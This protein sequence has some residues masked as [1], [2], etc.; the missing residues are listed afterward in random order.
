MAMAVILSE[1]IRSSMLEF[2]A[3][4]S[5]FLDYDAAG[6]LILHLKLFPNLAISVINGAP[7]TLVFRNPRIEH[8][9]ITLYIHDIID[10][11]FYFSKTFANDKSNLHS[12]N[13]FPGLAPFASYFESNNKIR[14][15]TFDETMKNIFTVDTEVTIPSSPLQNWHSIVTNS[16]DIPQLDYDNPKENELT[17]YIIKVSP[18][19]RSTSFRYVNIGTQNEWGDKPYIESSNKNTEYFDVVNY[20]KTG[21]LGYLQEQNIKEIL[22]I[23]FKP[24]IQL[25]SSPRLKNGLEL[26]DFAFGKDGYL[27]LLESKSIAAYDGIEKSVSNKSK[28]C[29]QLLLAENIVSEKPNVVSHG[30]LFEHCIYAERIIKIC[31]VGDTYLINTK[32]LADSLKDYNRCDLPIIMSLGTFYKSLFTLRDPR[33]I[34][35]TFFDVKQYLDEQDGLP[36]FTGLSN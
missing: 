9:N 13:T 30:G 23:F 7:M 18:V 24:E 27:V 34:V 33:R 21:T 11:P 8:N 28:A 31:L 12:S 14:V 17:G 29:S 25:F 20:L 15:A 22:S 19:S 36:I 2:I 35:R 6:I 4:E 10:A 1:K 26:T 32:S 3:D 16:S 5:F